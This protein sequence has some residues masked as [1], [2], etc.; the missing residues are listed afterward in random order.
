[1]KL[2]CVY[3]KFK[4]WNTH[5]TIKLE[6]RVDFGFLCLRTQSALPD[7]VFWSRLLCVKSVTSG[8]QFKCSSDSRSLRM[9][10]RSQNIISTIVRHN[11]SKLVESKYLD[12]LM[13]SIHWS[14]LLVWLR[15]RFAYKTSP[16]HGDSTP[17]LK[18]SLSLRYHRCSL[19]FAL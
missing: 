14:K 7:M 13:R 8:T 15:A 18:W 9:L 6:S 10:S 4:R 19:L 12:D 5:R 16:A 11:D 3:I 17:S 1:M 2:V